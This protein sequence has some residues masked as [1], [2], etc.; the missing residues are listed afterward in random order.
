MNFN[1]NLAGSYRH[2]KF[3]TQMIK[4]LNEELDQGVSALIP[5]KFSKMFSFILSFP[6]DQTGYEIPERM[7]KKVI[8]NIGQYN[9]YDCY[10]VSKGL[11]TAFIHRKN[12]AS[13][14][15]FL[16]QYVSNLHLFILII[17]K[18]HFNLFFY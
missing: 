10:I 1:N 2:H 11:N 13:L 6:N 8:D 3:E 15:V 18:N 14:P 9:V 12:K 16:D 7:V 17:H 5:S 4:W